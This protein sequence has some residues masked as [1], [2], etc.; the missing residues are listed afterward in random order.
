MALSRHK[1]DRKARFQ[2]SASVVD[3]PPGWQF[4]IDCPHHGKIEFDFEPYRT[5]GRD[6]LAGHFR[7]AFWSLRHEN[8]GVTLK[9]RET[10]CRVF[11]RFLDALQ[12]TGEQI[13]RLDQIDRELLDRY[14]TWLALQTVSTGKQKGNPLGEGVRRKLFDGLK[15]VLVNRQGRV[16][17]SV[18]R[19]LSFPFNP[20]PNANRLSGK[21]EPY[22]DSEQQRIIE[23]LNADLRC[24]HEN[25]V[26][27]LAP[28]Q[29][30]IV[31]LIV[32][33]LTT[34]RN[35]QSLLDLNRHA[36][37]EHPLQD[38]EL[39]VSTK[40]RGWS[41]HASSVRKAA[42][43]P[44]NSPLIEP[45]PSSIG[46]HFRFLCAYTAPLV[47]EAEQR[48][49]SAAFLWQITAG[50]R[51][52]LVA[53]LDFR[54]ANNGA[55]R[56]SQRHNLIDDL[57][58]PLKVNVSRFR[59]T[60]ANALYRRT[61]DIRRVQ[62]ALGHANIQT[63]ARHYLSAPLEAERNHAIVLD[64]MVG[65]FSR[66]EVGGKVLIAADGKIP[67]QDIENLLAGG[68]NT[69]V[70]RCK[71]PFRENDSVCQK[72]FACFK[73]P[74][75]CVFEDDLWRLF[76]FYYRLLSERRK[77]NPI[78]W[79]KT[80]GPIIR[81]IDTD[82]ASQF[83]QDKVANARHEAQVNPHPAWKGSMF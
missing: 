73:C 25:K 22:S 38:R 77:L 18:S 33:A 54:N 37:R 7:D 45:I 30:L 53:R 62:Q 12:A 48:D 9:G 58:Q 76:S 42:L 4:V 52:G 26:D 55:A 23:A 72:F 59:P 49:K 70:A 67:V 43:A 27:E 82:I 57:G 56:F 31:H 66:I 5:N 83:P 1:V 17:N 51:K 13:A 69:G 39:L 50:E 3:M 68:Y 44:K 21:R 34:A 19:N 24:I 36:L 20:F 78:H 2:S 29:V 8:V 46:D 41:T 74:S 6:D 75:M 61:G 35:L 15:A 80:Y 64:S 47:D 14:I 81:R 79:E 32:L 10:P 60:F 28:L 65:Q 40:R 16:P 11:F 71:N 63:T